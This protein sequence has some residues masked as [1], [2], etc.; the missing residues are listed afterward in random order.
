M[1]EEH[2]HLKAAKEIKGE[3]EPMIK[4]KSRVVYGHRVHSIEHAPHFIT[5][6]IEGGKAIASISKVRLGST[7]ALVTV[8]ADGNIHALG[9]G[10]THLKTLAELEKIEPHTTRVKD[11]PA[12]IGATKAAYAALKKHCQK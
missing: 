7:R 5:F 11:I 2:W 12:L 10:M 6:H 3:I 8:D 4:S 9:Q 1:T